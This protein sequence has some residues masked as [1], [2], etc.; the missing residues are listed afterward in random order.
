M[1][2]LALHVVVMKLF[3]CIERIP[4]MLI[5]DMNFYFKTIHLMQSF[6]KTIFLL[7]AYNLGV[8][9]IYLLIERRCVLIFLYYFYEFSALFRCYEFQYKKIVFWRLL[10]TNVSSTSLESIILHYKRCYEIIQKFLWKYNS[11]KHSFV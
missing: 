10:H 8:F 5:N 7:S 6:L 4:A 9:I 2:D 1:Y 11:W 3:E